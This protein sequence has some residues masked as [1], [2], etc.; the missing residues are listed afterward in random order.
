MSTVSERE[1]AR[2]RNLNA[3]HDTPADEAVTRTALIPARLRGLDALMRLAPIDVERGGGWRCYEGRNT[4]SASTVVEGMR[5]LARAVIEDDWSAIPGGRAS[6]Y[7]GIPQ[8]RIEH[9]RAWNAERMAT[10]RVKSADPGCME[11]SE[12]SN[13]CAI[14]EV[15]PERPR[16]A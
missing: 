11:L 4:W 13:T 8:W 5:R 16:V 12:P 9:Q 6:E 2:L 3:G 10:A 7:A 14:I 1:A 15:E